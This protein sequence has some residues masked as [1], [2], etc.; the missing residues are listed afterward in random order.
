MKALTPALTLTL[1]QAS[2]TQSP[3]H[4]SSAALELTT[5]KQHNIATTLGALD[6]LYWQALGHGLTNLAK[7]IGLTISY[8][9]QYHPIG[10]PYKLVRD[11]LE[12]AKK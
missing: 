3:S 9:Y 8:S 5:G 7:G 12:M 11:T 4:T 2:S 1:T 10:L 6:C